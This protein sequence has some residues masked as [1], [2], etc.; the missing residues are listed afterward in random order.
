MED[1]L[2][3]YMERAF[4]ERG[5]VKEAGPGPVVT[6]SREFGCPSKLVAHGLI[7]ELDKRSGNEKP[8]TWRFISKEVVEAT[9]HRL[10]MNPEEVK[11]LFS[12]PDKGLIED[13]LA[14][15]SPTYISNVRMRK[16]ITAVMRSIAG[17][18]RVIIV[19]RGGA[20]VLKDWPNSLHIRLQAPREWRIKQIC[21]SNSIGTT[22]SSRLVDEMDKKRIAFLELMSGGK[23]HPNLF[24]LNFNCSSLSLSE[25]VGTII[26]LMEIKKMT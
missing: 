16:T 18:G 13:V 21:I 23:F 12:S 3:E 24:D 20:G 1:L 8:G 19:G 6:I 26:G 4:A 17:Q 2:R 22:E 25:I 15:F 10:E 11:Y 14:S 9:A 7:L 5:Y